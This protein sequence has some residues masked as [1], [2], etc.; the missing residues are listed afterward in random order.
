MCMLFMS[1]TRVVAVVR[2]ALAVPIDICG[3]A[4]LHV[5]PCRWATTVCRLLVPLVRTPACWAVIVLLACLCTCCRLLLLL[6]LAHVWC[7]ATQRVLRRLPLW[8]PGQQVKQLAQ[9]SR[10]HAWER[11]RVKSTGSSMQSR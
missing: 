1:T 8:K 6:L 11:V 4:S 2:L 10:G 7:P 3:T 5:L 9:S